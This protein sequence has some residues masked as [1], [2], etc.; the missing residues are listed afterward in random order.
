MHEQTI[1]VETE[2]FLLREI[3]DT[4]A[5][6]LFA[7]D[8][9]PKVHRY[10][11]NKPFTSLSQSEETVRLVRSQYLENGIGRWAVIDKRTGEFIGWSGLK[12]EKQLRP[13]RVYYDL[14][15]R[16]KPA[17]WGQG[18]A[19]ETAKA[20]LKYG[21]ET[22]LLSEICAAAHCDNHASN[23]VLQK[24]GLLFRETFHHEDEPCNWYGITAS[25]WENAPIEGS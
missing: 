17:Y 2:R 12:L 8:S 14:G 18:I 4:D 6:H 11:G 21:F 16:L 19:T 24:V 13:E 25:A 20:A 7:L 15:Y 22:L 23:A 1:I 10:L 9:D 3:Q 5:P